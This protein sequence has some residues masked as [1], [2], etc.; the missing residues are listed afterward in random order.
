VTY[1]PQ[2]AL[3][4]DGLLHDGNSALPVRIETGESAFG[5]PAFKA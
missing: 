5:A 3:P 1:G 2:Y 4:N